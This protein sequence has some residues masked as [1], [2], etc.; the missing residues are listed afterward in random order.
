MAGDGRGKS[1]GGRGGRRRRALAFAAAGLLVAVA[2]GVLLVAR[3]WDG[4]GL[5]G[6]A[7]PEG[8]VV[9]SCVGSAG[10]ETLLLSSW[11]GFA[12]CWEGCGAGDTSYGEEAADGSVAWY[13]LREGFEPGA[14]VEGLALLE[15]CACAEG[16]ASWDLALVDCSTGEVSRW[17]MSETLSEQLGEGDADT[18]EQQGF[19]SYG[20]EG[21]WVAYAN[22]P[23]REDGGEAELLVETL[24]EEGSRETYV[25]RFADAPEY[26]RRHI[27]EC[28][29]DDVALMSALV[30]RYGQETIDVYAAEDGGGASD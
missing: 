13:R 28:A 6:S 17:T 24:S 12:E 11:S 30:E 4:G 16:A 3:P 1:T 25:V 22:A 21:R 2:V 5:A 27:V 14:G 20:G 23:V 19:V 15:G 29:Q 8:A 26:V 18:L 10:S 9:S 7:T